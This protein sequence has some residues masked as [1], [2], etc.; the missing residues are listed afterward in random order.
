M[1]A[2]ES[3]P[4]RCPAPAW[5]IA[6]TI[7]LRA[8]ML[9]RRRSSREGRSSVAVMDMSPRLRQCRDHCAVDLRRQPRDVRRGGRKEEGGEAP[10]LDRLATGPEGD[11][12]ARLGGNLLLALPCHLSPARVEGADTVGVEATRSERVHPDVR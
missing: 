6:S 1:S 9:V 11:L 8:S 7:S 5:W 12:L 3:G 4:P 10:Q 2:A